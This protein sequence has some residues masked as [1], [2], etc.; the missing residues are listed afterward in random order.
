[1][2]LKEFGGE[3][4]LIEQII[5]RSVDDLVIVPNGDD[6]S[7][8][9]YGDTLIATSTDTIVEGDHF[10]LDYFTPKQI[11]IKAIES[12]ASDIVAMGGKPKHLYLSLTIPDTME[13]ET[14][15]GF[16]SGVQQ[17]AVRIGAK[18]LGGD[19]THGGIFVVS[20]TV[21]G[22]IENEES[23]CRRSGAQV[24]DKIFV[25]GPIGSSTAGLKLLQG[26]IDGFSDV[27]KYHLEPRCRVDLIEVLAP[28]ANAMIDISD[29]L[30]SEIHHICR[31]SKCGAKLFEQK[32]PILGRVHE[33]AKSLGLSA[34]DFAY[35]GG[36]DFELLYCVSPEFVN[37]VNGIEI[38]EIVEGDKIEI[39]RSGNWQPF[40]NRG[41]D[42]FR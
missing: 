10:S 33:A 34:Y 2:L 42:H 39:N 7:V 29:G 3:F 5:D 30:S 32:V 17:A 6:A 23:I 14:L 27:V 18:V 20:V 13:V 22:E 9:K 25:S 8:C 4:K 24:G 11:G 31:Q 26:K 35:S 28:L 19:T 15:K 40:E 37:K 16:Y 41:Y 12:S 1:M 21:V 36:E 38:G